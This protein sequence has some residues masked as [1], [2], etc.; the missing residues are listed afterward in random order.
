MLK[1][2]ELLELDVKLILKLAFAL[3]MHAQGIKPLGVTATR[4]D[5]DFTLVAK[6]F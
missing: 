5:S 2:R 1:S 3:S 4:W 6:Y